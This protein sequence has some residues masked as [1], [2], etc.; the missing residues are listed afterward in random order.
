VIDVGVNRLPDGKLC[1]DVDYEPLA[2]K[3]AQITPVPGG[4]GD[5]RSR[6]DFNT[7]NSARRARRSAALK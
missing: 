4:V 1:G 5:G 2:Q 3:V 6:S 7:V